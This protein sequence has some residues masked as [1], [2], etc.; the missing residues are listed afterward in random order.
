[1]RQ[2]ASASE[3]LLLDYLGEEVLARLPVHQRELL[4][5]AS[6]VERFNVP[7]L[8][9]LA[10]MR[11]GERICRAD[12]ERLRAL[13]LYR[14]IPGLSETWFAYHPL[15]RDILRD[16]LARTMERRRHRRP[17]PAHRRNGSRRLD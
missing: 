5:R 14:E 2:A 10:T 13:E 17:A 7:L 15:F 9:A 3:H 6:L 16:E 8:E 1:M 4:L 12:L 11:G